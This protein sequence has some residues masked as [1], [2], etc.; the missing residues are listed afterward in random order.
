MIFL[1]LYPRYGCTYIGFKPNWAVPDIGDA[2]C[3]RIEDLGHFLT[4]WF[5]YV[6]RNRDGSFN[7]FVMQRGLLLNTGW[8]SSVERERW[9]DEMRQFVLEIGGGV[10]RASF[11]CIR[12]EK[13]EGGRGDKKKKDN[14]IKGPSFQ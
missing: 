2:A 11:T 7:L 14:V 9:G 1:P 4:S 12:V 6:R 3:A 13:K 8:L 10:Q 5:Y